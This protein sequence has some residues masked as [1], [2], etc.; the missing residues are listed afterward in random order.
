MR[1]PWGCRMSAVVSVR[2]ATVV[3]IHELHK[4]KI[5]YTNLSSYIRGLAPETSID[6]GGI[7]PQL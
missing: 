6:S 4:Y 7:D 5:L 1:L 2:R 3:K